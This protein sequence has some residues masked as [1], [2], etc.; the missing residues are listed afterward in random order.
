MTAYTLGLTC[1][2]C[3]WRGRLP[4]AA[5]APRRRIQ[6]L[7]PAIPGAAR[8]GQ[9]RE[10]RLDRRAG[11]GAAPPRRVHL[12]LRLPPRRPGDELFCHGR[13]GQA[14]DQGDHA[15]RGDQRELGG[16]IV[17]QMAHVGV[18]GHVCEQP[19]EPLMAHRAGRAGHPGVAGQVTGGQRRAEPRERDVPGSPRRRRRLCARGAG[20][21][22]T[23]AVPG[24]PS[25]SWTTARSAVP[26]S[27]LW[28]ASSGSRS[29]MCTRRSGQRSDS[30]STAGRE[31]P[32][33]S[34]REGDHAE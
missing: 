2:H 7:T 23:A 29:L 33:N 8:G 6:H 12:A 31:Q 13:A 5:R 15:G 10:H 28:R 27:T 9:L 18:F 4:A 3:H 1:P 25:A 34:S 32:A 16:E 19:P 20:S 24:S 14:R 26:A 21:G 11:L 17:S 22:T 30:R